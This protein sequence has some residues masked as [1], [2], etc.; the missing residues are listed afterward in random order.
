MSEIK[1]VG[2]EHHNGPLDDYLGLVQQVEG[3]SDDQ[4]R[5]EA[6]G[7][8]A[9]LDSTNSFY[10]SGSSR[11]FL[12]YAGEKPVGRLTA[13]R[14]RMLHG[15]QARCGMVGLFA[16]R[17]DETAAR[18]L[19]EHA[20]NWIREQGLETMRGPMAGDIWHRW[21]FMTRGFDTAP[22]PGEPRQ[23]EYYPRLFTA[24]G[25]APVRVYSTKLITNMPAQLERFKRAAA[26]NQQRGITYRN[27]DKSRWHEELGTLFELCR[28]SFAANWGVTETSREE[29]VSI[30][31][32]WLKRCGPDHI[33]F[34]LDTKLDVVGLGL[35]IVK[36]ADTIN[37]KTIAI[38]PEHSG[39]GLGQ[40]IAGELYQ[41]ALVAGQRQAQHCLMDP[42]SPVQ[43]WDRGLGQVTREYTIYERFV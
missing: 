10:A 5:A 23:P 30:Y 25:F 33:I 43:H 2:F 32:R 41:R 26:F 29:F 6:A 4:A 38:L 8:K 27:M 18:Q 14:N 16:C 22:F 36:P 19:L 20:A 15:N 42:L 37:L 1:L 3:L 17:D 28:H 9:L 13:F 7:T 40:A 35:A 34:A 24:A 31:D 21:R 12:A 11:N 39:Y